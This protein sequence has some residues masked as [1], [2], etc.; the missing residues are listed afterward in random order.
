MA[1]EVRGIGGEIGARWSAIAGVRLVE[2]VL[3]CWTVIDLPV[4]SVYCE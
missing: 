3:V 1:L 4:G 2:C